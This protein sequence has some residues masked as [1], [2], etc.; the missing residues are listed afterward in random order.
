M[1]LANY[2]STV[3][4]TSII[5]ETVQTFFQLRQPTHLFK[6]YIFKCMMNFQKNGD[7]DYLKKHMWE[8]LEL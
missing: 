4:C 6:I 8:E 2:R 7:V 5:I 1:T 3:R